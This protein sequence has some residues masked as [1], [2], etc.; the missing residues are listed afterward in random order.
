DVL[1]TY[2]AQPTTSSAGPDQPNVC[3]LV[4]T[5]AGNTATTGTGAWS[6]VSGPGTINF[7]NSASPTSTATA[8][9]VGSYTLRWTIT[10]GGCTSTDDVIVTYNAVPTTANAGPNQPTVCGLVATLAGNAPSV[11]TGM[12]SQV[13]GPGTTTFSDATSPSSTATVS[14]QGAY[15]FRW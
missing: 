6:L 4:A 7:S 13:G 10:N 8:S 11:G 9:V 12:W 14:V 1:V 2:T 3:G 5:L 15:T